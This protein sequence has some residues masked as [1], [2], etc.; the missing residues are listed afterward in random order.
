M[1]SKPVARV[2]LPRDYGALNPATYSGSRLPWG[3]RDDTAGDSVQQRPIRR[4][5]LSW[6][7]LD[8]RVVLVDDDPSGYTEV[9]N[10]C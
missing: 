3:V 6:L 4:T 1:P 2:P 9:R 5:S 7:G 8:H 10:V